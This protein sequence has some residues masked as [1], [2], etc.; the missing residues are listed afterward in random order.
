M[1]EHAVSVH[2]ES[3][4]HHS[5]RS[6]YFKV[7]GALIFL[8]ILTVGAAYLPLGKMNIVVALAIAVVKAVLIVL[9]FM[10]IRDSDKLTWLVASSALVWFGI[11]IVL[12]FNDYGTRDWFSMPGK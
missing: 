12:M 6:L 11:M 5:H 7:F 1:S 10:H 9:F 2:G 4:E 3:H 8:L